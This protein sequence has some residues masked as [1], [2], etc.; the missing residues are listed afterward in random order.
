M[1]FRELVHAR[2]RGELRDMNI[3]FA[4]CPQGSEH[5]RRDDH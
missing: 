1:M 4:F 5:L 2:F 3:V